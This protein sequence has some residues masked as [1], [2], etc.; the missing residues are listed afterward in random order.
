VVE[1]APP[2]PLPPVL[3]PA[4]ATPPAPPAPPPAPP[5]AEPAP[6]FDWQA[7]D[8]ALR[9]NSAHLGRHGVFIRPPR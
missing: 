7:I 4:P 1:V 2:A 5:A 6:E 9:D 3:P 8:H